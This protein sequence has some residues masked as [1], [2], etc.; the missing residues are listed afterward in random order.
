M[1]PILEPTGKLVSVQSGW[2]WGETLGIKDVLFPFMTILRAGPDPETL[3]RLQ[4]PPSRAI[5]S[6]L[7]Y[8]SQNY[9]CFRHTSLLLVKINNVTHLDLS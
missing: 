7:T 9:S 3:V 1:C 5:G 4:F 8:Y 2:M 6:L